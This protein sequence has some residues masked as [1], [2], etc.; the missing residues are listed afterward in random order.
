MERRTIL[1]LLEA[2]EGNFELVLVGELCGIVHHLNPEKRDDRHIEAARSCSAE[3]LVTKEAEIE[4]RTVR[5][6]RDC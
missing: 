1:Q 6:E 4:S 2:L 3:G 5:S